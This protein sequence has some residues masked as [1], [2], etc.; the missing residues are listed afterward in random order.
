LSPGSNEVNILK[1]AIIGTGGIGAY[2]GARLAAGG[3]DVHFLIRSDYEYVKAHGLRVE[4]IYGDFSISAP[5]VYND[6]TEMPKCELVCIATKGT[7]ND[8]IFPLIDNVL[9]ENGNI[10]LMQNGFGYEEKLVAL[11]PDAHVFA[12]LCFVCSF[13]EGPGYIN[14]VAYGK[15][16]VAPYN[17]GDTNTEKVAGVF[18]DSGMSTVVIDGL[19][20]ARFRK[21]VWNIPYNGLTVLLDCTTQLLAKEQ[22]AKAL[23][24]EMMQEIVDAAAACGITIEP[25]FMD[26]ML[27]YTD[28]MPP[29]D[30]SMKLDWDNNRPLEIKAIYT[31][32]IEY[33]AE[34]G[35]EMV[36]ARMLKLLLETM[37]ARR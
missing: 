3:H 4:S 25:E 31:N 30:P 26:E 14:H 15:I 19:V 1:I 37:E 18:K 27:E 22:S 21:L 28:K 5:N 33:A 23:V 24:I 16:T 34:R 9:L 6:I 12:G 35:Y 2:Y 8:T 11:Y 17:D 36:R 29:Y 32:V 10:I 13:R 20:E 7:S